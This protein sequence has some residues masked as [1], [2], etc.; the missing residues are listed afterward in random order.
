MTVKVYTVYA[1]ILMR[2]G[3]NKSISLSILRFISENLKQLNRCH[4]SINYNV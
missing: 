3:D 4:A 1:I 2:S